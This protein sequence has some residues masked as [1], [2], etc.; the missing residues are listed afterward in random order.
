MPVH[1][2]IKYHHFYAS[3]VNHNVY[4]GL[5]YF[6]KTSI[7]LVLN[8]NAYGRFGYNLHAIGV[9]DKEYQ[10]KFVMIFIAFDEFFAAPTQTTYEKEIHI[11]NQAPWYETWRY[12]HYVSEKLNCSK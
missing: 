7:I 5:F 9:N 2:V 8:N 1:V 12:S 11:F 4:V 6:N 3:V 10:I